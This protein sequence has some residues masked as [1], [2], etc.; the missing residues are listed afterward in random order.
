MG[1]TGAGNFAG[2]VFLAGFLAVQ[3]PFADFLKSPDARNRVFAAN[4]Y[5]Y[6]VPDRSAWVRNV[7]VHTEHSFAGFCATMAV[8][9]ATSV[10][11]T[12]LGLG[13]GD[14]MRRIRR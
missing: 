9:L 10:L 4:N 13:W 12:R 5:P 3:W 6:F 14:W 7:F 2:K 1:K 8:A 11:M